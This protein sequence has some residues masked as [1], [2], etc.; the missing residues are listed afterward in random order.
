MA[1]ELLNRLEQAA[2]KVI[3]QNRLLTNECRQLKDEQRTWQQEKAELLSEIEQV[4]KRLEN[5][6]AEDV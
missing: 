3:E 4:L 5:I 6:D 1:D 2:S